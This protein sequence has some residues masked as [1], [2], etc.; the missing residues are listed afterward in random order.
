[1]AR[2]L[3]ASSRR[4]RRE[5]LGVVP[6][7]TNKLILAMERWLR[8]AATRIIGRQPGLTGRKGKGERSPL[9]SASSPYAREASFQ[10]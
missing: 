4:G 7:A 1:M 10:F 6:A 2:Q 5:K 9:G 3:E 8:D